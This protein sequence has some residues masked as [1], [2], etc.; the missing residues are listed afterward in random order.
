MNMTLP[1]QW[2]TV[3]YR[4]RTNLIEETSRPHTSHKVFITPLQDKQH[5][6]PNPKTDCSSQKVFAPARR[7]EEEVYL[8]LAP[9][10]WALIDPRAHGVLK[11][12][13]RLGTY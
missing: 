10:L 5:L 2:H 12:H 7:R 13:Q 4:V 1:L 9:P 11:T 8:F 6:V 3:Q